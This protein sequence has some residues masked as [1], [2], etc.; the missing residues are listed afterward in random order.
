M[1]LTKGTI[2]RVIKTNEKIEEANQTYDMVITRVNKNTYTLNGITY[3][4]G[5]KLLKDAL[6][7]TYKDVYGTITKY[8]VIEA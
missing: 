3:S 7:K 4:W 6:T 5:C 2:I 8:E 1:T